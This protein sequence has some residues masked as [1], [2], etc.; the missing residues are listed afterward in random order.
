M[1]THTFRGKRTLAGAA[2]LLTAL[3]GALIFP[4]QQSQ[5]ILL[6]NRLAITKVGTPPPDTPG[7]REFQVVA[8][9]GVDVVVQ[10]QDIFSTI[11]GQPSPLALLVDRTIV[12]TTTGPDS[13]TFSYSAVMKARTSS[14]TFKNVKWSTPYD[15]VVLTASDTSGNAAPD[16]ASGNVTES[17]YTVPGSTPFWGANAAGFSLSGCDATTNSPICVELT[18]PNSPTDQLLAFAPCDGTQSC[19][20]DSDIFTWLVGADPGV[21]TRSNPYK[22]TVKIDKSL[23]DG[24]GIGAFNV[25]I[26]LVP[27]GPYF[28]P[29]ACPSASTVGAT[30][31]MCET[32]RSSAGPAADI[33]INFN[34]IEDGRGIIAK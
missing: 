10:S 21:V 34:W 7:A 20:V 31:I 25:K 4:V 11:S 13:T 8:G 9:E 14:V 28:V 16:S 22:L 26:Q 15:G 30:Q 33:E 32:D 27:D 24:S 1:L 5:A 23:R 29:G 3:L 2:V 18:A 12:L 6:G 19:I 17:G